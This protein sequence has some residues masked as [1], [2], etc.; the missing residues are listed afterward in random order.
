MTVSTKDLSVSVVIPAFNQA[1]FIANA[2]ESVLAQTHPPDEVVVVDDG[3]TDATARVLQT[4]LSS[5]TIVRQDNSGLGAARN[6]GVRR[7][8]SSWIALLDADDMWQPQYLETMI[9][10]LVR[11]GDADV[12]VGSA[13]FCLADGRAIDRLVRAE[14]GVYHDLRGR[15]LRANPFIPSAAII[16]RDLLLSAGG[17]IEDRSIV[18]DWELW[19]R[20]ATSIRVFGVPEA[21]IRYRVHDHSISASVWALGQ[22][23]VKMMRRT[24][25][26]LRLAAPRERC[27]AERGW[28]GAF[29]FMAVSTL[30]RAGDWEAS[31]RFLRAS[32]IVDPALVDD[33]NLF[34][35]FALGVHPIGNR[36]APT[37]ERYRD[38]EI[39]ASQISGIAFQPSKAFSTSLASRAH[40]SLQLALAHV[41]YTAGFYALAMRHAR[42]AVLSVSSHRRGLAAELFARATLRRLVSRRLLARSEG[43]R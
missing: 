35:E 4:Y 14:P 3:S 43:P 13:R 19:L 27:D 9:Q 15:L 20:L 2:I 26:N 37:L 33:L 29:R 22:R 7:A 18:E 25:G 38:S 41:A 10:A 24:V 36:D 30:S 8:S 1:H 23:V 16:R 17:F 6:A 39:I 28:G 40:G 34:H 12:A 5:L 32:M 31:A 42:R 11:A 21:W